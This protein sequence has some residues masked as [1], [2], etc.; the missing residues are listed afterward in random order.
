MPFLLLYV[1]VSFTVNYRAEIHFVQKL[2]KK[3]TYC[4]FIYLLITKAKT[5]RK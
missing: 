2:N 1:I 4:I 3:K 5:Y